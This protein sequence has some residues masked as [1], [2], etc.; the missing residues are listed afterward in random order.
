[1]RFAEYAEKLMGMNDSTWQRHANL[2]SGWSRLTVLPAIALAAWSRVLIGPWAILPA[3]AAIAWVWLNP[4]LFSPPA[5]KDNWMT[6]GIFGER[7]WL[8]RKSVPIPAGHER[9]GNVLNALSAVSGLVFITGLIWLDAW[10][11]LSG[12]ALTMLLKLWFLDRMAWLYSDIEKV[13]ADYAAWSSRH[14]LA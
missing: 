4:R 6:R 3:I 12:M 1:M 11:T 8:N 10:A 5:R 7:V 2:W 14:T 13:N 9:A